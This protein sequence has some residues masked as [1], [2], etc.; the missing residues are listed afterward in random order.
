MQ[1]RSCQE[2]ERSR[3]SA[4]LQYA[5]TPLAGVR[6]RQRR[7]RSMVHGKNRIPYRIDRRL[8]GLAGPDYAATISFGLPLEPEDSQYGKSRLS[9]LAHIFSPLDFSGSGKDISTVL[10]TVLIAVPPTECTWRRRSIP[11]SPSSCVRAQTESAAEALQRV[12]SAGGPGGSAAIQ[13]AATASAAR[14]GQDGR[15][16]P[17][18]CPSMGCGANDL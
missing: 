14:A 12:D 15:R 7:T 2:G 6:R 8:T 5:F 9:T 13:D 3:E 4:C 16:R 10:I 18:R 11:R 17:R 1:P